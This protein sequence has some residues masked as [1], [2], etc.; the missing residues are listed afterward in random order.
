MFGA[1]PAKR[2]GPA[3]LSRLQV[4]GTKTGIG[5]AVFPLVSQIIRMKGSAGRVLQPRRQVISLSVD[6]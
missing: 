4:R 6:T 2:L 3:G 5:R 1:V